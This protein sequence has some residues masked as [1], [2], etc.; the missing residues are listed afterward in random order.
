MALTR[1]KVF[2][3]DFISD[4]IK[5]DSSVLELAERV[6]V[7]INSEIPSS[8][9]SSSNM[10]VRM[11]NGEAFSFRVDTLKG[12]PLKPMSLD[13][14]AHKFKACLE[15]SGKSCLVENSEIIADLIFNLEKK[16]DVRKIFNYV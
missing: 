3:T 6:K 16:K 9:I 4:T 11:L 7:V 5:K 12:S 14:C 1:G 13:E 10:T 15:Y 8:D 2:L